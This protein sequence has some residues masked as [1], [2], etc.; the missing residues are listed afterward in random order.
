VDGDPRCRGICDFSIG[1]TALIQYNLFHRNRVAALLT[2]GT[3]Y[4]KIRVAEK[5]ISPPRLLENTDGNPKFAGRRLRNPE[6]VVLPD[7]FF[8]RPAR[9]SRSIDA[10]NPDPLYNDLDGTRN[11]AGFTGGPFASQ[12]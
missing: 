12:F 11:D 2:G 3:N 9:R 4:R 5:N 10:G 6:G 7:D 1:G 8:L